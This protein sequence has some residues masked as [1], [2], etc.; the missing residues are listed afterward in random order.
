MF[1]HKLTTVTNMMLYYCSG[2]VQT[3]LYTVVKSNTTVSLLKVKVKPL[4]RV[5]DVPHN[6]WVAVARTSEE[7]ITG[8]CTCWWGEQTI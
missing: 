2:W 8:H 3:V 6:P 1:S 4:Q 5:S 7:I